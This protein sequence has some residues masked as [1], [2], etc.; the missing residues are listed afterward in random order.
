MN[1]VNVHHEM[2]FQVQRSMSVCWFIFRSVGDLNILMFR[3]DTID[4]NLERGTLSLKRGRIIINT[5]G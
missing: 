1:R 3:S 5:P 4:S 2:G